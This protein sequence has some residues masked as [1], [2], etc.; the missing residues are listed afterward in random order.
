MVYGNF[1]FGR[2]VN[3]APFG[4]SHHPCPSEAGSS[5]PLKREE[6]VSLFLQGCFLTEIRYFWPGSYHAGNQGEFEDVYM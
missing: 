4:A 5:I 2:K 3:I 1:L 6:C